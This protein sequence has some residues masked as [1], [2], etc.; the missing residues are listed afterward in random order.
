[1]REWAI[2]MMEKLNLITMYHRER[3]KWEKKK[4]KKEQIKF[5]AMSR[6]QR[7]QSI[8]ARRESRMRAGSAW[9]MNG[10]VG[11]GETKKRFA[12]SVEEVA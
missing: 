1:M 3:E 2:W 10:A 7:R 9:E 11:N 4:A 6:E 8:M 12:A 5:A